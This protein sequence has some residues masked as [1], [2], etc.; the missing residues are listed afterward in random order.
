MSEKISL[1]DTNPGIDGTEEMPSAKG[2]SNFK[3]TFNA[4]L[5]WLAGATGFLKRDG[6]T[7]G[8]TSQ[9]QEFTL[10]AKSSID[11]DN[12]VEFT[13]EYIHLKSLAN[14]VEMYLNTQNGL[15]TVQN[16]A[17]TIYSQLNK[18]GFITSDVVNSVAVHVEERKIKVHLTDAQVKAL[19]DPAIHI[20]AAPGAGK[21]IRV[22]DVEAR[23]VFNTEAFNDLGII[24]I[25]T[26]DVGDPSSE[27][28]YKI[29]A[30]F[31]DKSFNAIQYGLVDPAD[32]VQISSLAENK[33]ILI[34]SFGSSVTGDGSIDLYI[35]YKIVTL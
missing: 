9:A 26:Q 8:A 11:E 5:T 7:T 28:Q 27:Y 34:K 31:T 3:N 4:L 12:L 33:P 20:I 19:D 30:G 29:P 2:G 1:L 21:F 24:W 22:T 10:G 18:G 23:L 25:Y 14:D 13:S 17:G 32:I 15:L 16:I 6:T 35:T